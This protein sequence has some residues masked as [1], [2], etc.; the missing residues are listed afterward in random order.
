MTLPLQLRKLT[1]LSFQ[2][3]IVWSDLLWRDTLSPV[4]KLQTHTNGNN[5]Q[6][7]SSEEVSLP[8]KRVSRQ[9]RPAAAF[10]YLL[11]TPLCP[12]VI[13]FYRSLTPDNYSAVVVNFPRNIK[14]DDHYGGDA[15]VKRNTEW[16]PSDDTNLTISARS[17]KTEPFLFGL[18]RITVLR[19]KFVYV[20]VCRHD[21]RLNLRGWLFSE[22]PSRV[23][24]S[25]RVAKLPAFIVKQFTLKPNLIYPYS[26]ENR[27]S[28]RNFAKLL[29]TMPAQADF[30]SR[31]LSLNNRS[32]VHSFCD[33]R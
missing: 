32:F 29:Q 28:D 5:S 14:G 27:V 24:V 22:R 16:E 21:Y 26:P 2:L 19:N 15:A 30:R 6:R 23:E 8:R 20:V 10:S 1:W 25:E 3:L 33:S 18:P 17:T 31:S 11:R 12:R 9:I 4:R 7:R 13:T